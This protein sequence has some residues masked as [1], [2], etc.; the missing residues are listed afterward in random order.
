MLTSKAALTSGA[1]LLT[2]ALPSDIH[3]IAAAHMLE[4][5]YKPCPS[6]D[7]FFAGEIPLEEA[8]YDAVA[9][10][11]GLGRTKETK[12]VVEQVLQQPVSVVIDADALFHLPDLMKE[13]KERAHAT[14]LTP[15]PG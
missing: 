12:K 4:V 6:K 11:P 1:G 3:A 2:L 15:H 13:V 14:I 8:K 10:G 5:M 9:V 7:G